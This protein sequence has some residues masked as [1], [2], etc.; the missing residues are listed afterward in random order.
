MGAA[1]IGGNLIDFKMNESADDTKDDIK[2][3]V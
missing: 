1:E 2:A 3:S